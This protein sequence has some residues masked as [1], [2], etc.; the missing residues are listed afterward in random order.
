MILAQ[1]VLDNIKQDPEWA[2]FKGLGEDNLTKAIKAANAAF[3]AADF[4]KEIF[5]MRQEAS[6]NEWSPWLL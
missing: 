2:Q 1:Q 5:L 6:E 3:A 4:N